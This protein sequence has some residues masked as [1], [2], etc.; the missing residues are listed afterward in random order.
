MSQPLRHAAM[1]EVNEF[2]VLDFV[3]DRQTTT[4]S[5]IAAALG[6]SPASVSR[7]V[8][9]LIDAELVRE[10]APT[11]TRGRP[12]VTIIFNARAASVIGIDLGGTKCHGL[13]ADLSGA[14]LHEVVRPTRQEGA[15]YP[16]L[17]AVLRELDDRAR[18]LG[19]PV[20]AAA[21]GVPAVVEPETGLAIGG[22][23]VHWDGFPIVAEL[24]RTTTTPFI[25][26]ND[27][28]LAALAHAW[29]GDARGR[30]DFAVIALGTGIGAAV[31][32]DGQ[33]VKGRHS[34]AG[35]VGFLVLDRSQL[36]EPRSALGAFERLAAG[37]VLADRYRRALTT[38]GRPVP[39]AL[40][41]A[42]V[43]E[44]A[45][46]GEPTARSLVDELVERVAMAVI[47][48]ATVVDPE[49]VVL[50]GSIGQAL[51]PRV[52][53]IQA[54]VAEHVLVPPEI[55]V[56]G[57]GATATAIGAVAAALQLSR[58]QRA[59]SAFLDTFRVGIDH[60]RLGLRVDVA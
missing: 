49:T 51:R 41:A 1:L 40:T 48:L 38:A 7:I 4:R 60:R 45:R 5:Q 32:A 29:R 34:A 35:E 52:A 44:A 22:P 39:E 6:L 31:V 54:L 47:A 9:R 23:N 28:N 53:E 27:V 33:L 21:V 36:R 15:P 18:A 59:P 55:V 50:E 13:L 42:T 24:A 11:K 20:A 3:R 17:A 46:T 30:S 57:L 37:P 16:T 2:L 8:R 58:H 14:T 26:E 43:F 56:S 12:Q 25:V 10:G 19:L